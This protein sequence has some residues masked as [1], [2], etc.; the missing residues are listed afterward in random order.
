MPPAFGADGGAVEQQSR[1]GRAFEQH[2]ILA[3]PAIAER[4]VEGE[5]ILVVGQD[6][7]QGQSFAG[8]GRLGIHASCRPT[9]FTTGS[10]AFI[11]FA[12]WSG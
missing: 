11:R 12:N 10:S 3:P 8:I 7:E 6:A 5:R 4:G 2:R 9:A 1:P